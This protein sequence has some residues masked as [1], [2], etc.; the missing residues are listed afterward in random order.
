MSNRKIYFEN[1]TVTFCPKQSEN[2]ERV[3]TSHFTNPTEEDYLSLLQ[4]IEHPKPFGNILISETGAFEDFRKHFHPIT[5]CGGIIFNDQDEILLIYRYGK[6]DLPKGKL[7]EGESD[8]ICALRECTEE[9]GLEKIS[10]LR[11]FAHTYHVYPYNSQYVLKETKWYLMKWEGG[12][13]P[14]P[15]VEEDITETKWVSVFD[16]PGYYSLTY[17]SLKEL[18]ET[19]NQAV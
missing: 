13:S 15:Q 5:A 2:W 16:L 6:W 14:S 3:Y 1:G 8:R 11:P 12:E 9:T 19:L 17:P 18:L 4:N 10:I 7:E